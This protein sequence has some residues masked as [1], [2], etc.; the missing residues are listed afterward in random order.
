MKA[1]KQ[2]IQKKRRAPAQPVHHEMKEQG[3]LVKNRELLLLAVVIV[4]AV[5]IYE[6]DIVVFFLFAQPGAC[7][8]FGESEYAVERRAYFV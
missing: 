1:D 4:V 8:Q 3:F 2:A 6:R 7:Q 5:V